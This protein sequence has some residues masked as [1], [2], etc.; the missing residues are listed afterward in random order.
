MSDLFLEDKPAVEVGEAPPRQ[1]SRVAALVVLVA[2]VVLM[3]AAVLG[4]FVFSGDAARA[5]DGEPPPS[6][7]REA[8]P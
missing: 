2:L 1:R 3:A 4:A 8:T 6:L 7:E 5:P